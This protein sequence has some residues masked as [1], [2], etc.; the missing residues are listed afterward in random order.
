MCLGAGG[1]SVAG[2]VV[3]EAGPVP[4]THGGPET[5]EGAAALHADEARR[6]LPD[7]VLAAD[8]ARAAALAARWMG[9]NAASTLPAGLVDFSLRWAG[10]SD[11]SAVAVTVLSTETS[12]G[13]L[14][15]RMREQRG[16]GSPATHWG[17]GLA[18]SR[19]QPFRTTWVALLS[20]RRLQ[21]D[22]LPRRVEPGSTLELR[23]RWVGSGLSAP[24][25]VAQEPSGNLLRQEAAVSD[26]CLT[27]VV[28]PLR[29][30]GEHTLEVVAEGRF[31]PE[32]V[33]LFTVAV[34]VAPG[35]SWHP[36]EGPPRGGASAMEVELLLLDWAN[37]E[38]LR[39]GLMP[40]TLDARLQALARAHSADMAESGFFGH[41]SP[42]FGGFETRF[43]ASGWRA[44]RAAE[45]LSR[46]ESPRDA[47]A[48]LMSS[49]VHRANLLAPHFS[50]IGIGVVV[51][52][53]ESGR[54]VYLTTQVFALP[55]PPAAPS[56]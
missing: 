40:L 25:V 24:V 22:S 32:V 20:E 52:K 9:E 53:A 10:C 27:A 45:N 37:E 14:W 56:P 30:P 11:P 55:M 6:E 50:H 46:S 21:L 16:L 36:P 31:G 47:Q 1:V 41:S 48:G 19:L 7:L 35:T 23:G 39:R 34:G 18:P 4:G 43:R 54:T 38:R 28:G 44:Q 42:R 51:I 5:L 49:P 29:H 15:Q 17:F 8:L 3:W 13:E 2:T 12:P 33:A 26:D